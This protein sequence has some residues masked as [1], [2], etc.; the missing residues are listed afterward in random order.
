MSVGDSLLSH[1][2]RLTIRQKVV[3][4]VVIPMI[5][6]SVIGIVSYDSLLKLQSS[7]TFL[8]LADDISNTVLETRRFEKNYLLYGQEGDFERAGM[9]IEEAQG[10]VKDLAG[11]VPGESETGKALKALGADLAAY[12]QLSSGL[13]KPGGTYLPGTQIPELLRQTGKNMVDISMAIKKTE[14]ER[15]SGLISS[16]MRQL[17]VTGVLLLAFGTGMA[18][19]L[20]RKIL[21]ALDTITWATTEIGRGRFQA[22]DVPRADDE[23]QRVL[24]AFNQMTL[25]LRS[26]QDQLVQEKKL[27]SLG[28]LTSGIAHQLNNPLNNISTSC[29]ILAEEVGG[30]SPEFADQMLTNIKQEVF[31]ARDIVKGLLDFARARDFSVGPV[32][33]DEVVANA[34]RLVSSQA[35]PGITLERR[36]P[37]GLV[38]MMDAVRMQEVFI[39]LLLN[40]VQAIAQPPGAVTVSAEADPAAGWAV[41]CVED[42]GPGIP[43]GELG[44][45]FDPFF[46]TKEEGKGT[47]LGLSVV[48]GI[49][50]SH[51]GTITAE[52]TGGRGARFVIRLPLG[53][54]GAQK[55]RA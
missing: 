28:V 31:R 47:G 22:L 10:A 55:E 7:I 23:T 3:A 36:I 50:E 49:I 54:N 45:V 5:V 53:G 33:L 25:E 24:K 16:V 13:R 18:M 27:S 17:V 34:I 4:G 9:F 41:I 51:M 26:R 8:E 15:V 38:L 19:I 11:L 44:K 21:R 48:F 1:M 30:C 40:A 14:R 46:T 35:P 43:G 6:F 2:P 37:E 42:T 39:N 32:P 52:Q 12:Q 20:A 29:Q